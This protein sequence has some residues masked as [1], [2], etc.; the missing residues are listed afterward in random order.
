MPDPVLLPETGDPEAGRTPDAV[1]AAGFS[2][3]IRATI[4]RPVTVLTL[5]VAAV[6]VG[7][8]SFP[9]IRTELLPS[10]LSSGTC[11]VYI[12]VRDGTPREVMDQIAKPCEDMLRT[13]PGLKGVTTS[14][15]ATRCFIRLEF[16]PEYDV[17]VMVAEVRDRIERAMSSWPEGVDRYFVWRHR[18]SDLPVY[19]ASMGVEVDERHEDQVDL[20]YIFDQVIRKRLQAVSGVA[21]IDIWG[22]LEKRVEVSLDKEK[23]AAYNI[24]LYSLVQR[25]MRDNADVNAGFIREGS[26]EYMVRIEGRL[27]EF[28]E[29]LD[30]PVNRK[31]RIEDIAD[32]G[33]AAAVRD[34][35]SRVNGKRSRVVFVHK[36]SGANAVDVSRR[37]ADVVRELEE[38]LRRTVPGVRG[39]EAHAWLNQGEMITVSVRSLGQNGL[40][41][42]CCAVVVL[43]LFLR[44]LTMTI[45]VTLAIPFSLLITVIWLYFSGG[46]FNLLTLM[47]LSLGIGMLVDNSIVVVEN[48]LRYRERGLPPRLAAIEGVREVGLAVSLAT[49]TTLMVFLPIFF[50]SDPRFEAMTRTMATPLCV[51]VLASLI[52]A[53]VFVPQGAIVLQTPLRAT[54]A[55]RQVASSMARAESYAWP[56]RLTGRLLHWCLRHRKRTALC[57]VLLLMSCGYAFQNLVKAEGNVDGPRGISLGL[58]LPPNFT[59]GEA[60]RVFAR[61]EKDLREAGKEFGIRS[62]TSWFSSGGGDVR[63]FFEPGVRV[64]EE[65][66]FRVVRPGLPRLPGV[67]YHIGFESFEEDK[68]DQRLRVF[69]VGRDYDRLVEAERTIRSTLENKAL[70]PNLG[71]IA[72][73]SEKQR[74]EV[75]VQVDRRAAQQVGVD[76]TTVSRMVSWAL[77]GAALPDFLLG[78]REYPFWICYSDVQK[79]NVEELDSILIPTA[80]GSATRLENVAVRRFAQGSGDIHR[81]DGKMTVGLSASLRGEVPPQERAAILAYLGRIPLPDGCEISAT[82]PHAGFQQDFVNTLKALGM[83]LCLV[84]FVMGVLFESWLLPLSILLS[85]PFALFGSIWLLYIT[86]VPLDIVGMIGTLMLVGVVVNNAI[87]LVDYVNRLRARGLGRAQAIR[88]AVQV[89]FRPVW[90]TAL[91]T[92]FGLLPLWL[93]EQRGE[94]IDYKALAVVLIGGLTTSTFFTLFVVPLLYTFL[95][96]L[97]RIGRGLATGRSV[98]TL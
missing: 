65:D 57:A 95:D 73:W 55:G 67:K 74:E 89:R 80:D 43:Y 71:D 22:L 48:I 53:L 69:I 11:G 40:Y 28:E 3:W 56:N 36:E 83:A 70:F 8:V 7:V 78:G 4:F 37:V 93:L 27:R 72:S 87:V 25:L 35:L 26:S 14:S 64:K 10:G 21:S 58:E 75:R 86:R 41:G 16:D 66:F 52:V 44:R 79:E 62:V 60:D 32:V 15:G 34:R 82:P 38:T 42:G 98:E 97:R 6:V 24:D 2:L 33:L 59:L 63:V 51:S 29:V 46:S 9:R 19:I 61:V 13:L 96:D 49:L 45:L 50:M 12:P 5:F 77:R 47:G 81:R 39:V 31:F 90:M 68:G 88:R 30:Y 92:I 91:T 18:D 1:D 23:V 54:L 94:G 17:A 76:T 85:V 84:F 20:D